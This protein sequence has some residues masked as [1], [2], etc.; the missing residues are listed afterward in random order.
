MLLRCAL[1]SCPQRKPCFDGGPESAFAGSGKSLGPF[2]AVLLERAVVEDLAGCG[3]LLAHDAEAAV[4]FRLHEALGTRNVRL[5]VAASPTAHALA[6]LR[7][8]ARVTACAARLATGLV[9]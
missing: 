1:L 2:R 3:P 4:A 6:C 9:G 5:F 7:I 8:A